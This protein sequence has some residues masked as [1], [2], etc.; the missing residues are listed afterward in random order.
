[1]RT[2]TRWT[3]FSLITI[4]L[5]ASFATIGSTI[6]AQEKSLVWDRFDVDIT[7]NADGTFNVSEAQTIRFTQGSFT[8]GYRDIPIRNFDYIDEWAITDQSG[9]TYYPADWGEEP[10]TFVVEEES[11]SYVIHWYFPAISNDTETYTLSYR[12]HGGLRI[13][14][15]G[16]QVWWKAI[17]GDRSF[18]VL[19]GQVR[20]TV[21]NAAEI[22]EW[23]AYV[24]NNDARNYASATV[25]E[26]KRQILFDL[27][28][29]LDGGEEFEVRVQFSHGVVDA[30]TPA[31]QARADA[32][33]S[34]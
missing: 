12:V 28:Q 4:F 24:N 21:P 20:I 5:L 25:A 11:S 7:V 18:P 9:N 6:Y 26:N 16:D 3:V 23:A 33:H 19:A 10:Y 27:T 13:Y 2:Y 15:G 14:D 29:R 22:Q 30:V 34:L 17:Y 8:F 31:W 32:R 1:M